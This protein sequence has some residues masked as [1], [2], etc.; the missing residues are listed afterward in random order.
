MKMRNGLQV[1]DQCGGRA[2][3]RRSLILIFV[4]MAYCRTP[5]MA[6]RNEAGKEIAKELL[7]ALIESQ[8]ER[9][10]RETFGPGRPVPPVIGEI[11]RPTQATPEM[12]QIRRI[13]ASMSQDTN[14]L[15]AVVSEEGRRNPDLRRL[16]ADMIQFQGIVRAGQQ[17]ADRENNHLAMQLVIQNIDQ[18]WKPLAHQIGTTRS[19]SVTLRQTAERISQLDAQ[20]CQ[21]LGIR[22]QFNMRELVRAADVLSADIRTLTDEVNYNGSLSPDRSRL[23]GRLRKLQDQATLFANLA[24]GG[25]QFQAVVAEY[26]NLFQAWQ[27]LRP[28]LDQYPA[29]TVSRTAARIQETHRTIHQLLRLEFSFDQAMVQKMAETLEREL[30]ELYRSITL[31]QMLSLT[32]NRSLPAAA[33]EL[34][35][36]AQNLT[37]I[38]TRKESLPA[39]G[40]AWLYLQERWELFEFYLVTIRTPE[41]R[42]RV[43]GVSQSIDL[44]QDAIGVTVTFD[45]RVLS[46]QAATLEGMADHLQLIIRRWLNRSGQQ[47]VALGT[48]IQRLSERCRELTQ[49]INT[50]R[51]QGTLVLKCDEIIT[52]WQQLR[53]ALNRCETEEKEPVE[54][55]IDAFIPALIQLHTMLE[56]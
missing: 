36:T 44:L 17:R 46:R 35:G 6:Q 52:D 39:V 18:A 28:E 29:R 37:D 21:M 40:E 4:I 12:I 23:L 1:F 9:Q 32:D 49:L 51:D 41:I 22:D 2:I 7:R 54:Q 43:E 56:N 26:R 19:S 14:A 34:F 11:P 45:R 16:T 55:T 27:V 31:E 24:A 48:Q 10:G 53:P 42:R 15:S 47:D 8:L 50:G 13:L 20:A 30:T 3:W 5:A 33:D 38:V 25:G